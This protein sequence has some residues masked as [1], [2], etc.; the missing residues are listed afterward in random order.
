[1]TKK[2]R[3]PDCGKVVYRR[4]IAGKFHNDVHLLYPNTSMEAITM[5][6]ANKLSRMTRI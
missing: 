1:M 3:C 4:K 6:P 5:C 2:N